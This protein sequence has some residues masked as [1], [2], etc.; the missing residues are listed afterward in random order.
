MDLWKVGGQIVAHG[1]T[2]PHDCWTWL[3]HLTDDHGRPTACGSPWGRDDEGGG[4]TTGFFTD[5]DHQD[6]FHL[7]Y[8]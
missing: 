8:R 4:D 7:D 2:I 1:S 3:K 5:A 6:H